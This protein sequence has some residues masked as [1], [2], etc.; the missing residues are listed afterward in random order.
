MSFVSFTVRMLA[1]QTPVFRLLRGSIMSF[2]APYIDYTANFSLV[3]A[4]RGLWDPNTKIYEMWEYM[5]PAAAYPLRDSYE[6]FRLG[7]SIDDP[8]FKFSEIR[9]VDC[10]VMGL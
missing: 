5:R 2:F 10:K 1:S 8:S 6:F 3:G 9:S 7:S 4:G